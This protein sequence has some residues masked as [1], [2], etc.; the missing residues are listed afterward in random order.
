VTGKAG[1]VVV[2]VEDLG[3]V[4]K[5][6]GITAA[7]WIG[8]SGGV[9]EPNFTFTS[10][11]MSPKTV[12]AFADVSR[13]LNV[14]TGPVAEGVVIRELL[15]AN[16]R[17]VDAATL[18]GTGSAGQPRG[19]DTYPGIDTRSGATFAFATATG[20]L[21]AIETANADSSAAAWIMDP[22]SADLL[23][24]REIG[25]A[26]AG[27]LIANGKMCNLPV[28]VSNSVSAG[29]VFLGVWSELVIAVRSIEVLRNP[30]T[31]G[32]SGFVEVGVYWTGDTLLR[33]PGAFAVATGT[34]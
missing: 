6:S 20:M 3:P 5:V 18:H 16:A 9:T 4:P 21:K 11:S 33:H 25:T 10:V 17:A 8:E 23:R 32:K 1:A 24:K 13:V 30:F 27:L 2:P 22:A 15:G 31:Q 14:Q 28:L 19:I 7:G 29:Y 26:G 12:A 34:T